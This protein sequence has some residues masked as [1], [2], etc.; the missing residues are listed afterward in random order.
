MNTI[1][2]G[3]I[4][5]L[6]TDPVIAKKKTKK[7]RLKMKSFITYLSDNLNESK[8]RINDKG[9]IVPEVCDK[10]GG[11]VVLQ[12]HGEP[13]YICKECGKYFGTMPCNINKH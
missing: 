4:E 10:C 12:I 2:M 3:N 7:K 5:P 6:N 11:K 13:V 8:D 1:G 9:E